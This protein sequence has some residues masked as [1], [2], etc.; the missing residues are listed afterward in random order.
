M[1]N[2]KNLVKEYGIDFLNDGACEKLLSL[3]L[4]NNEVLFNAPDKKWIERAEELK[5]I[6][7]FFD[8]FNKERFRKMNGLK[9]R[10]IIVCTFMDRQNE[11][12]EIPTIK[13]HFLSNRDY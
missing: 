3:D 2:F 7:V 11:G 5:K 1:N 12:S 8:P 4:T 9:K 10:Y 13:I 6:F